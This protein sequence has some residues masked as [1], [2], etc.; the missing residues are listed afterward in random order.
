MKTIRVKIIL[1]VIAILA[2]ACTQQ[3][4]SSDNSSLTN[5]V[6]TSGQLASGTSFV[7]TGATPNS[8]SAS[9]V[10][11]SSAKGGRPHGRGGCKNEL[12]NGTSF[13]ATTDELAAI[14]DAESAGDMR[15]FRM[16]NK[17]GA[18]VTHYDASGNVVTLSIP[19]QNSGAPE[20]ASFSGKQFP[21]YDSL[22]SKIAKTIV[23]FGTGVTVTR[24]DNSVTRSGSITITR[25][26]TTNSKTETVT[27]SDYKVNGILIEG[28]KT[29]VSTFDSAT[30][31]GTS[32]TTVSNGK[33]TL[34]DGT[35]ATWESN[36]SRTSS[37]VLDSSGRP[38]S[39]QIKTEATSTVK[40]GDGTLIYSNST[41]TP[42]I[43]KIEC[44]KHAPVSGTVTT[45]YRADTVV[46]DF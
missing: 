29:R 35:V 11:P 14:V 20:G 33:L 8:T 39:G 26:G 10:Q 2:L 32:N 42:V 12:L 45:I 23:D 30:G 4:L 44:R 16:F 41:T 7:I 38:S 43:E 28:T 34:A 21:R 24:G 6:Q 46:L 19:D 5:L 37:I 27:Y 13:I 15:G 1:V 40:L 36:R 17:S 9:S 3:D 22:L 31:S 18:T 25:T